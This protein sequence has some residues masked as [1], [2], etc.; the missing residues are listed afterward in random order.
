MCVFA[1]FNIFLMMEVIHKIIHIHYIEF[2]FIQ[3]VMN[4]E[5]MKKKLFEKELFVI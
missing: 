3:I 2:V 4:Q 1:V 5:Q